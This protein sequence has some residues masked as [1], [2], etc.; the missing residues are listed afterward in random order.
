MLLPRWQML[1]YVRTFGMSKSRRYVPRS[2]AI[3]TIRRHIPTSPSL[4]VV[5]VTLISTSVLSV[6]DKVGVQCIRQ[7]T[8]SAESSVEAAVVHL[9]GIEQGRP[10]VGQPS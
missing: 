6:E 8:R 10:V 5:L 1:H 4:P 3:A 7:D 2:R 9:A